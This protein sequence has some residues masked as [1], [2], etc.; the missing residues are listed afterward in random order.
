M[1]QPYPSSGQE[2]PQ[3]RPPVPQS[4]RMAVNFMYAGA[5][6]SVV[7]LI[8][9]LTTIGSLRSVLK[10]TNPNLT[11]NQVHAALVAGVALAVVS[12]LIGVG[13]WLWMA[14]ANRAGKG[15][16][17]T[18]ATVFFAL[19]TLEVILQVA[20]PHAL[21]S[22]VF[23]FLIWLVGLGAVILLWRRESSSYFQAAR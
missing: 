11:A 9:G 4:V 3:Q 5:V 10:T 21:L 13:L 7:E 19:N 22:L 16:A 14:S 2:P 20:R 18:V 6:L 1:Y 8:I 23:T 15:W 17:R 12:G